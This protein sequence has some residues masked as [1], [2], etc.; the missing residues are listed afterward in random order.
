[1][2]TPSTAAARGARA[3]LASDAHMAVADSI[4]S[5]SPEEWD[6]VSAGCPCAGRAWL[7]ALEAGFGPA[8]SSKYFLLYRHG[9]LAGAAIAYRVE[10]SRAATEVDALLFGRAAAAAARAG[11]GARRCLYVGPL[12]GHER[13]VYWRED[14]AETASTIRTLLDG[15]EAYADAEGLTVVFGRVPS[16]EALLLGELR[17]RRFVETLTWPIGF[18]EIG[19]RTFEEYARRVGERKRKRKLASTLRRE[20]AAPRAH[21]IRIHRRRGLT[22]ADAHAVYTLLEHTHARHSASPLMYDEALL[23]ALDAEHTQGVILI[24]ARDEARLLGA[25]LLLASGESASVAL[26]GVSPDPI[27]RKAF[28]YFNLTYYEPV[29]YC[30]EHGIRRLQLGG[31]LLRMK[32]RRGCAQLDMLL[33]VRPRTAATAV[34]WRAWL[35]IQRRWVRRKSGRDIGRS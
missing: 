13:H 22:P 14:A 17:R 4:A 16:D 33:F 20:A 31:G 5:V 34:L 26:I 24:E 7:R 8:R 10:R 30:I 27:N 19:F 1:M 6:A 18:I 35:A 3:G 29:R 15:V 12:I 23:E 11:V 28:T 25:A 21:G 2:T 9:R 32:G